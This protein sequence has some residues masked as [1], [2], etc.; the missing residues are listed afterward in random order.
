MSNVKRWRFMLTAGVV[1]ITIILVSQTGF[2][3][4]NS[5]GAIQGTVTDSSGATLQGVKVII[6]N[7]DNNGQHAVVTGSDGI[8]NVPDLAIGPYRVEA[9]K[10][11]FRTETAHVVVSVSK[12]TNIDIALAVGSTTEAINVE[13]NIT[14]ITEDKPDRGVVLEPDTLAKLPIQVAGG[15]R[16]DDSFITLAPGVTGDT[17]S[18]R[19]NGAPDFTQ[20]FYYDGIPYMNADGGGRQEGAQAPFESVDEYSIQ[21]NAYSAQYGRGSSL[22]NF[23]IRSGTNR[24]HGA[25]YEYLRNN[26]L[27][28]PGYF[29]RGP[30]T[31]KQHEFG[32]R[33][34]GPV[35]IPKVYDGKDKTFFYTNFDWYKFRGG[36]TNSLVTLPT[37]AMKSGDFSALLNPAVTYGTNPCDGTQVIQG[38]IFDPATTQTVGGQICR[39]AFPGNII[40]INR[41][42][43]L[44]AKFIALLPP[45]GT[46]AV[47]NNTLESLPSS[48]QNNL[49]YLFKADHG[50]NHSLALHA[51]YYKGNEAIPTPSLFSGPLGNGNQFIVGFW[52]PRV[53]LDWTV[54]PHVFNQIL[55]ST[56]YTTGAR[57]YYETVPS[58][59][60]SAITTPG[61]PF[62]ALNVQGMPSFGVGATSGGASG[63]CWPCTFFADNLKWIKGRH[64]LSFGT[65]LRWED[66][67]NTY[68]VNIGNYNF[69]NGTTS[70][71]SSAN[72]GALGFGFASLFLGTPNTVSQTGPVNVRLS[73]TGY[74]ALYAQ[75]DIKVTQK[76]T[77]N[78]GLRWDVSLPVSNKQGFYSSFDPNVPNPGAGGRLGSLVFAGN[79]G[80]GGCVPAGSS[81]CNLRLAKTYYNNWQPRIGFAYRLTDRDVLRGGFG[82]STIRGGAS[83]LMGPE[84]AASYLN[85][86]QAEQT[87]SSPDNGFSVPTAISP[88]WDL[89]IPPVGPPPAHTLQLANGQPVDYLRPVDGKSGYVQMW[90]MTIEHQLPYHIALEASYVG[91]SSVRIGA[92]L[93]NANQV[94]VQDL[95]LGALLNADINSPAAVAAGIPLPYPGFTGSVAQALRP[96]PQYQFISDNTQNTG[97]QSY[98]SFQA[99]AQKYFSDGLSFIA[100]FTLSKTYTDSVDQFSTFGAPPPDTNNLG[101]EK[102]V[103]GG[104]L[105]N[106]ASPRTLSIAPTYQLPIG[107]GKRYLPGHGVVGA[108]VGGWGIG[109]VLTYNAGDPLHIYGGTANPIFNGQERPNVVPGVNPYG[110]FSTPST[111][112]Y[113]NPAAFSDPGAFALGNAPF[114]FDNIRG[115]PHYNENISFIKDTSVGER[116]GV[117]EFR[118]D[119]FNI[120]NRVTFA[121]PDTNWN[122][123]VTNSFGKV[124]TQN[125]SPRVIQFALRYDF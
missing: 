26:V 90:S 59:F 16:L 18:A 66:E 100:S 56:Q 114:A 7:K 84:I 103:L 81:Y 49:F 48:P 20:D 50:I 3:Q 121:D 101:K 4:G 93:L 91:S 25:A 80:T 74:R 47:T 30:H 71:P 110:H 118:C 31:E 51:S 108:V 42:S 69:G 38:Q 68:A 32:F 120:F 104:T 63:G 116:W 102:S 13:A 60:N 58:S 106:P 1:L 97:H 40:P 44:S 17:F 125:N 39:T 54:N 96:Y 123:A 107:P 41:Q 72:S 79:S 76:F 92:N 78:V 27:D 23:H 36:S 24:L 117:V 12:T 37:N 85:G 53:S 62:P 94:P 43:P 73:K 52:E 35:Y 10:D 65:E 57:F 77:L 115:F 95:S 29:E 28:A 105:F 11:G 83:T 99:R 19:I 109:G 45:S 61:I 22:L 9:Q 46:Q 15:A 33:V 6:T 70:L 2:A 87:L 119:T 82:I 113:L 5:V 8:Y 55:F 14:P 111:S 89:G 64:N 86:Y 75:D 88:T 124:A 21:T 112:L 98:N 122:D 67:K 34:G